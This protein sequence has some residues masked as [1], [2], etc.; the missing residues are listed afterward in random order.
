MKTVLHVGCGPATIASMT[1]GFQQGWREI[2]FDIDPNVRPDIVGTITGMAAVADGSVDAVFSAHNIEHVHGHQV[3]GVLREFGRVLAPDGFAVINCP[4]IQTVAQHVAEGRLT[5]MLYMSAVGPITALDVLYG[6]GAAIADGEEYMAHRT[7]FT[8]QTLVAAVRSAGFG[9]VMAMR[10]P[11]LF[12]LWAFATKQV[13]SQE[14]ARELVG[15][16][17]PPVT[18]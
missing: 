15:A 10:R 2:R 6:H 14:Q 9:S 12:D 5:D 7:A 11:A 1:P 13:V 16:Y 4:D 17:L 3:E 8:A 18:G